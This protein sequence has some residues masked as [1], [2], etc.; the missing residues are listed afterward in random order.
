MRNVSNKSCRENQNARFT[1]SD[2]SPRKKSSLLLDEVEKY[3][4]AREEADNMA[5]ARGKL[6]K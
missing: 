3:G 4:G 2:F 5:P 6:D 1:F